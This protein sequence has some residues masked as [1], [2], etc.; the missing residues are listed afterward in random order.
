MR[1][2]DESTEKPDRATPGRARSGV[3]ATT[4]DR[5]RALQS[6]VG[7]AGVAAAIQRRSDIQRQWDIQQQRDI[8][9]QEDT[10]HNVLAGPS[11]PLAEPVRHEMEAR[12]GANLSDVHMHTGAAAQ[13]SARE[14]GASAYTSGNH[15]VIGPGGA[16]AHT[17]AHEL[18]H[19]LQQRAGQVSGVDSA[20]SQPSHPDGSGLLVSEPTDRFERAAEANA[21]R[22]MSG[23]PPVQRAEQEPDE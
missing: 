12:L 15:V 22:V 20:F 14:V 3:D 6:T 9:R 5:I 21:H 1:A 23:R 17:L 11:Q 18:T 4:A 16:D 8:Q 19:V 2:H 7:N 13:R 10:V